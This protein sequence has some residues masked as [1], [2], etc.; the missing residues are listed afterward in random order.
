MIT[1]DASGTSLTANTQV[2]T[3]SP[4]LIE[5]QGNVQI[6]GE[7]SLVPFSTANLWVCHYDNL[8]IAPFSDLDANDAY[9]QDWYGS[10]DAKTFTL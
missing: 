10:A 8:D 9:D 2:A 7:A 5:I 1:V 4:E 6:M 3:A